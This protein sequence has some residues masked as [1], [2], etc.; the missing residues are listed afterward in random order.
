M[1]LPPG[2][3]TRPAPAGAR[4]A[5]WDRLEPLAVP[6][7]A[8]V[9]LLGIALRLWSPSPLWLDE[10]QSVAFAQ[11]PLGELH[12][13]LKTDGA[14]PLYYLLL[15]GWLSMFDVFGAGDSVW[16]AR[17][18]SMLASLG[19]LP[20]AY[21]V[22]RRLGGTRRHGQI[23]LLLFAA[24]PWS[25]RYAGE[26]RMYSL[27]VLLVLLGM[28]AMD[29][30]R[31]SPGPAPVIAVGAMTGALLLTHYWAM[32]LV[33]VV[34]VIAVVG[35]LRRPES[36]P[37]ARRVLIGMTGGGLLFLPWL[38]TM[39]YQSEHTGAPWANRPDAGSLAALPLD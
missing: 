11:L 12:G 9:V 6:A 7:I 1:S 17:S 15:H 32:F 3:R 5:W 20:L 26:A 27:V 35:A 38:P 14:P 30:L 36:R 33:A 25:V 24:N 39:L 4:A 19:A 18:L 8:V 13:A 37:Q 31:R 16:A 28:L 23:A 10:A 22:G 29:R 21:L 2:Q 34:G